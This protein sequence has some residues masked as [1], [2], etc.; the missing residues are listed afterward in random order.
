[1][2]YR[3]ENLTIGK[4]KHS[5][6]NT[7]DAGAH[8]VILISQSV[9]RRPALSLLH[10]AHYTQTTLFMDFFMNTVVNSYIV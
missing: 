10:S 9:V 3:G 5:C 7:T 1:M 4:Q 8:R 2:S 6:C